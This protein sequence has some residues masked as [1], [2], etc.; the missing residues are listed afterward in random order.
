[1]TK[2]QFRARAVRAA[3]SVQSDGI[4]F[5]ESDR[6]TFDLN[7]EQLP[8]SV[9]QQWLDL[10]ELLEAMLS[11][12]IDRLPNSAP[13]SLTLLAQYSINNLDS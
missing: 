1:M 7:F 3:L 4:V 10:S 2:E 9:Q 5:N 11:P 8:A 6:D 12:I 13:K